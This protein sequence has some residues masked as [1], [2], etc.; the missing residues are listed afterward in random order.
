MSEILA[1]T[2]DNVCRLTGLSARQLRYWDA[3]D[4]FSPEL[5][6]EYRRRTFG[7]IYSF[8]DVVGLRTIAVLRNSYRIPLQE[9]RR[10]GEW[11]LQHHETPW[12]SLRFALSNRKVVFHDS[13]MNKYVEAKGDGQS[14]VE[15][16]LE[17][18][19]NEMRTAAAG[20][21]DR[22]QDQIGTVVR[23]RYV[24]RNAWVVGGTRIPTAAIWNFHQ[25]GYS[26]QEIVDEYPQL[27]IPDINAAVGF[28]ASRHKAA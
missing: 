4:F 16:D 10:V 27:T 17:P 19:A 23:N 22:R 26:A 3:T 20:L 12:S 6:D 1:F 15:I 2:A 24:V 21:R 8:R 18:I 9:I 14:I 5:L 11:L 28:E 7:R 25:A 13:L